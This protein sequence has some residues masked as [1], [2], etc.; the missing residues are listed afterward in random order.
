MLKKISI[1]LTCR[2]QTWPL[3][4]NMRKT[5]RKEKRKGAVMFLRANGNG[6]GETELIFRATLSCKGPWSQHC[7]KEVDAAVEKAA[8]TSDPKEQQAGFEK[9]TD[10]VR[11]KALVKIMFRVQALYGVRKG[12]KFQAR[13][14]EMVYPWDIGMK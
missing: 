1:D 14:D 5:Y 6:G 13:P 11:E 9:V 12:I 4:A 3:Y 7:D 2:T 10:L 8:I